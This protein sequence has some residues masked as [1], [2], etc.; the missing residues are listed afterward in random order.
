M[1]MAALYRLQRFPV[2]RSGPGSIGR[3]YLPTFFRVEMISATS[4]GF[5]INLPSR[6]MIRRLCRQSC[7]LRFIGVG[8]QHRQYHCRNYE[9][10]Q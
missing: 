10:R 2:N 6:L 5:A 1:L 8:V 9:R 4:S 7:T 3:V